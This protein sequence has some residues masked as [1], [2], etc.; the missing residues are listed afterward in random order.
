M[1]S[2]SYNSTEMLKLTRIYETLNDICEILSRIYELL[3]HIYEI[4]SIIYELLSYTRVT[5]WYV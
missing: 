4:V 1:L 3:S 2:Y 5:R